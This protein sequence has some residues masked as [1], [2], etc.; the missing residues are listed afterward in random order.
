[1]LYLSWEVE[2]IPFEVLGLDGDLVDGSFLLV[3]TSY[4]LWD[5]MEIRP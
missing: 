2:Q 5:A 3:S 4:F 1:M